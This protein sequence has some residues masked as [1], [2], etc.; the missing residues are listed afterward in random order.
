LNRV[1]DW[2]GENMQF[3]NI[4]DNETIKIMKEDGFSIHN[5]HPTF[6]KTYTDP[7]NAK[8]FAAK[9]IKHDYRDGWK[10]CDMPK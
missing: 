5:G 4:G 8:Q 3:T 7:M 1:L 6:N 10:L 2:D 9:L